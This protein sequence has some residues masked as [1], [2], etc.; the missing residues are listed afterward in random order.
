LIFLAT[1]SPPPQRET[2][3]KLFDM[4]LRKAGKYSCRWRT[5]GKKAEG[6]GEIGGR[7][8]RHWA[9]PQCRRDDESDAI[10]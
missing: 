6:M 10:G 1:D 5:Y 7:E 3:E 2:K 8:E 4:I 9:G